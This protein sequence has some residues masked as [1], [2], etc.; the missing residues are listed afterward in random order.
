MWNEVGEGLRSG[1][2]RLSEDRHNMKGDRGAEECVNGQPQGVKPKYDITPY[3]LQSVTVFMGLLVP[4]LRCRRLVIWLQ[5]A[6]SGPVTN[7]P[8]AQ[9]GE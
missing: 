7:Q 9:E 8:K 5:T 3:L 6:E 2:A 1:S 4:Y